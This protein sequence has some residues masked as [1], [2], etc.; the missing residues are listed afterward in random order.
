[1]AQCVVRWLLIP[2]FLC[3]CASTSAEKLTGSSGPASGQGGSILTSGA[4][5]D[6]GV[7]VGSGG[8]GAA[9]DECD[10]ILEVTYRDFNEAH[11]DFEMGFS[12][13]VVRLQLVSPMIGSDRRPVFLSSIGCPQDT[14]NPSA[15]AGWTPTQPVIT[16][17]TTFA[18]WYHTVDG[19]N[20]EF[21]DTIELVEQGQ[22][23]YVFDS[24][25]FFPLGPQDG[26]GVTPAGNPQGHN[27]LFTTELHMNFTYEAGQVFTFRGDDDLWI[28]VNDRLAL[29]LG[30]MHIAAQGTID[31]DAMASSL[32]IIPGETYPMDIFHAE[33]HTSESN[34][35]FE[36]NI[37]CF[38]PVPVPE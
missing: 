24:T 35:R 25:A 28:F 4:A 30:S 5:G 33:R 34:F 15:C 16:S 11:A 14:N 23:Q 6:S 20:I 17:A 36:T 31:F 1:M 32:G 27:F 26:F 18:E 22:N 12:G 13:D 29:D 9:S 38:T 37:S 8:T 19:T 21:P 7:S 10:N 3:A 2:G